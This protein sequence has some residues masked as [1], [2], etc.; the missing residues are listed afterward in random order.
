MNTLDII[1]DEFM[2]FFLN[3]PSNH[4]IQRWRQWLQVDADRGR[5]WTEAEIQRFVPSEI[6]PYIE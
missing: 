5:P 3:R 6:R 1:F 4:R 2:A